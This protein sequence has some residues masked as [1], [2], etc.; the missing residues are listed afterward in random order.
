VK[1]PAHE[2]HEELLEWV[3]GEYDS[4]HF[5]REAINWMLMSYLRWSRDRHLDWGP[6]EWYE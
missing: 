3:G 1:D 2:D 4:E 5:D 6:I